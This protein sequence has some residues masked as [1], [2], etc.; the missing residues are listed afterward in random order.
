MS[1]A[2]KAVAAGSCQACGRVQKLPNDLL[3]LHGYSVQWNTFV[4]QCPGSKHLSYEQ[5]CTLIKRFIASARESRAAIQ[6]RIDE[7]NQ[8]ATQ[9]KAWVSEYIPATWQNRHSRYQDREVSLFSHREQYVN[10]DD[11]YLNIWYLNLEGKQERMST[12]GIYSSTVLD[13]ATELNKKF[14]EQQLAPRVKQL[15]E[16][17]RWQQKRVIDWKLRPLRDLKEVR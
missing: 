11:T 10:S 13:A 14:A 9:P 12:R 3:A 1:K 7:L 4:G 2:N 15:D 16:Y 5:S 17:I 6:A 8:P